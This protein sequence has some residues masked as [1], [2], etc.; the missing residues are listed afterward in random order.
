[1]KVK[2]LSLVRLFVT[3]WTEAYQTSQ[4]MGFSSKRTGVGCHFLLQGIF[5]TQGLNPGLPHC[6]QTL[7]P[8]SH[9]GSPI[10]SYNPLYFCI[11]CCNLSFFISNFVDLILL[12][13]FFF[14]FPLWIW[15]EV[16]QFCLS[17]QRISFLVL[18][19]FTVVSFTSSSAQFFM[20]SFLLLILGVFCSSFSNFFRCKVRLS[21]QFFSCFLR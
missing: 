15:L 18:L 10:V 17:S 12:S 2:S 21:I 20:I 19:I 9:Q 1:M 4:S 14:F 8:L 11:V 6:R 3:P 7:Y 13:L 16:C 5:L